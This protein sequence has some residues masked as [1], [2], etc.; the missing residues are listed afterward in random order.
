[1]SR[2]IEGGLSTQLNPFGPQWP[3]TKSG[4]AAPVGQQVQQTLFGKSKPLVLDAAEYPEL[5]DLLE[6]LRKYVNK[7]ARM[8]GDA[9]G[10]YALALA[11][12]TIAMIDSSGVIYI[13]AGFLSAFKNVLDVLVGVVAHEVG[14]RPK[15]WTEYQ[16]RKQLTHKEIEYICRHEETRADIFAGK[17]L[18]ELGFDCEP[19]CNFLARVADKPH[20]EYFPADVRAE[21]IRDAFAGRA[22]R[23]VNR[24]KIF[25]GFDRM[26]APKGDLGEF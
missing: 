23:A 22:Y 10:D 12:G 15:R 14:H 18:A 5:A 20:P 13:G 4:E 2:R 19:L 24:K 16:V 26:T 1:M 25:P 6:V 8:A 17:G 7:L 9:E 21:V 3:S 11:N